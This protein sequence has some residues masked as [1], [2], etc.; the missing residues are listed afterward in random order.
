MESTDLVHHD[1]VAEFNLLDEEVRDVLFF[2]V[3]RKELLAAGEFVG[4]A[5]DVHH[6][7]DVVEVAGEGAT[8][9]ALQLATRHADGLRDRHGLANTASLDEDVVELVHLEE[10]GNLFQKV[11]LQGAADASV[12]KRHHLA[13]IFLRD[14]SALLD[15][16]LVDVHFADVVHDD[17]DVVTLLVVEHKVQ[18]G[19]LSG[20]EVTGEQRYRYRFHFYILRMK[21]RS[22]RSG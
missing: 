22:D 13:G 6:R 19:R 3:V 1:G 14:V 12:G 20:S 16:R 10:L 2:E 9:A 18:E 21:V 8:V 7:Y 4:E 5:C 11:G 15:E 17:G